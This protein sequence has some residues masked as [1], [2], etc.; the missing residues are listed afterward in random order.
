MLNQTSTRDV[1][2]ICSRIPNA[3]SALTQMVRFVLEKHGATVFEVGADNWLGVFN[4]PHQLPV[5]HYLS[6]MSALEIVRCAADV[7]VE[8]VNIGIDCGPVE[9]EGS[10]E[11]GFSISGKVVSNAQSLA[12]EAD[13]GSLLVSQQMY[14]EIRMMSRDFE[15]LEVATIESSGD[16]QKRYCLRP[17]TTAAAN[18]G[19][20]LDTLLPSEEIVSQVLVAEDDPELRS[21]FSKVLK[22]SGFQVQI[23]INGHEVLQFLGQAMPDVIILD[24]GMPG[25]SGLD[26]IR[27]VRQHEGSK[28]VNIVVVTGN[29]L[30]TQRVEVD[31][32]DLFL[33]KPISTR[34]LVN[35]VR[36]FVR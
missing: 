6:V 27:Y 9:F 32:A 7:G 29:H 34:D 15:V 24:L 4:L 1:V 5:A 25:V 28:H 31:A 20:R 16:H 17:V 23:A 33:L 3:D 8:S 10:V 35:F 13:S 22:K 11:S 36:R 21:L 30:A 26:V 18:P 14:D 19:R 2:A 12:D